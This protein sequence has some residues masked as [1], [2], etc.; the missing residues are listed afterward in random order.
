MMIS[1][2]QTLTL[3]VAAVLIAAL[4]AAVA[5]ESAQARS[6]KGAN[7]ASKKLTKKKARAAIQ[8]LVNKNRSAK[9]LRPNKNL[10]QAAQAHTRYMR[11][12]NCFSH[13]CPGEPSLE[14][15]V[16]RTGYLRGAR[17]F[18]L[19]EV[20]AHNRSRATPRDIVRQWMRSSSHRA[21]LRNSTYRHLGVGVSVR[22]GRAFYTVVVGKKSG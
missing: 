4:P 9:N 2:R 1:L 15:R 13:Q 5:P 18:A 8:C 14:G 19:G 10:Q 12:H 22:N 7:T 3:V 16:R 20:I 11:K 6:C 21:T 17:S